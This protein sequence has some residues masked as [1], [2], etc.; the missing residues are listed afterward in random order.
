MIAKQ[1]LRTF[2]VLALT[3]GCTFAQSNCA[4]GAPDCI[5]WTMSCT[6]CGFTACTNSGATST[7]PLNLCLSNVPLQCSVHKD[8]NGNNVVCANAN[9]TTQCYQRDLKAS[10]YR[11]SDTTLQT[12][13]ASVCCKN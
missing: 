8:Q 10:G 2:L 4:C 6:M 3:A 1:L 11:C 5:T 9:Q 12:Y 13:T 7:D